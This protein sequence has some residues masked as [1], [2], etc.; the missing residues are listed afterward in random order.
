MSLLSRC[1]STLSGFMRRDRLERD[2]DAELRF[3]MAAFIDDQVTNGATPGEAKRRALLEFGPLEGFKEDCRQARGLALLDQFGQ[4]LRYGGRMLRKTPGFA[5]VAIVT[6]AVGIGANTAIFSVVNSVLLR[7]L[8]YANP[9]RLYTLR[10]NQSL[11][12]LDDIRSQSQAFD[13]FGGLTLQ[14]LD[15]TGGSEPLQVQTGLV[16]ADMFKALGVG[17]AMG[18]T[19][20]AEDDGYGA[21]RVVVLSDAFWRGQLN[22]DPN[23]LGKAI[24]LSGNSYT[25]VGI[26]PA[27]FSTPIF[28]KDVEAW[29]ALK[30]VIEFPRGAAG[31]TIT[32]TDL[33]TS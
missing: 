26:M 13:C 28:G 15:Y 7:P 3:H 4:D 27:G 22:A 23:M 29:A 31:N 14:A 24:P 17:A 10:A 32:R 2:M 30:V 9:D 25:V 6:L 16:N 8:P 1:I 19:I 18:R 12:D 20:S 5:L 11:P 33:A 21:D